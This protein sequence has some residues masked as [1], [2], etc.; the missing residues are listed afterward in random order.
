MEKELA[1]VVYIFTS[2][3][4]P[5]IKFY[6]RSPEG[7]VAKFAGTFPK[8]VFQTDI[9]S[10]SRVSWDE[11]INKPNNSQLIKVREGSYTA[12]TIIV[13]HEQLIKILQT[14]EESKDKE[15]IRIDVIENKYQK[16]VNFDLSELE[17][18]KKELM[19]RIINTNLNNN[20]YTNESIDEIVIK[21]IK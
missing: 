19:D 15:H 8:G 1:N 7:A 2:P 4:L 12:T 16:D 6:D 18:M 10:I 13:S 11:N 3:E 17:Q 14:V 20:Y 9:H 5:G 21:N